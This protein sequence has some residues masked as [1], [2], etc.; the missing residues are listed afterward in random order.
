MMAGLSGP[1]IC[2][3]PGDEHDFPQDEAIRFINAGFAVPV[4]G[5]TVERAVKPPKKAKEK[6]G[7]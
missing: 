3:N 7:L 4:V 1:D 5:E 6:R 2:L